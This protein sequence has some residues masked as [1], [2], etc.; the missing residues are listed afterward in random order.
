MI[1]DICLVG[2]GIRHY[3][4]ATCRLSPVKTITPYYDEHII[5]TQVTLFVTTRRRRDCYDIN[6]TRRH[7]SLAASCHGRRY[8]DDCLVIGMASA[9]RRRAHCWRWLLARWYVKEAVLLDVALTRHCYRVIVMAHDMAGRAEDDD[10]FT[11]CDAVLSAG[12]R[13]S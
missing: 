3:A 1:R 8:G 5:Y 6:V 7:C 2:F 12:W 10:A 11:P 13:L 4:P 9:K